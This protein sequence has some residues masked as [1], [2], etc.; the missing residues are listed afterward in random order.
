MSRSPVVLLVVSGLALAAR[1]QVEA[2]RP[3][4]RLV[5][6]VVQWDGRPVAGAALHFGSLEEQLT[7]ATLLQPQASSDAEG[8]FAVVVAPPQRDAEET[9][10]LFVAA[11]GM[12]AVARAVPWRFAGDPP[13]GPPADELVDDGGEYVPL[14]ARPVRE[15]AAETQVGDVVLIPGARLVGRVRDAAGKPVAGV[16]VVARDLLEVGNGAGGDGFT[17]GMV[18]RIV[19][20]HGAQGILQGGFLCT[21]RSDA[22]GI[23]DLPCALPL[24]SVL[25]FSLAGHYR[26]RIAPVATGTPLEVTLRRSGWIQGRVLDAEGRSIAD[27]QVIVD[28]ELPDDRTPLRTGPDGSFRTW[29]TRPGR[30]RATAHKQDD[31][32]TFTGYS[33]VFTG[34]RENFELIAKVDEHEQAQRLPLRVVAKATGHPVPGFRALAI[35]DEYANQNVNYLEYRMRSALRGATPGKDGAGEVPGPGEGAAAIGAVRVVAPGFAPFTK[36]QVEWK[37]P[38]AG[39]PHETLAIEL[40][41]EA[42]L[43]GTVVDETTQQPVAGARVFARPRLDPSQGDYGDG[44]RLPAG[45]ATTGADGTFL[46]AGLGEGAWEV[47]VRDRRRPRCPPQEVELVAAQQKTGLV[48]A[49]PSGATVAGTLQGL[50]IGPAT[51]VF[52]AR[53]PRQAF[54]ETNGYFGDGFAGPPATEPVA[55]A[56][57][58]SFR[59]DGV[60]LDNHL[61]VV[62]VPSPPRLG[63]DLYLPIEPFRLRKGGLQR[64]FDGSEDRPG[65]IRGR[66]GFAAASVPFEQLV[67][68]APPVGDEGRIFFSP[69]D[70]SFP[71]PR[72]FV[73]PTGEYEVRV[74][75]GAYQLV[76]VD[77]ATSLALHS[78]QQRIAVAT[79]ATVER[80]LQLQLARVEVELAAAAGVPEMAAVDRIE[81]RVMTP[82][83]KA[84]GMQFGNNDNYDSGAG[85]P[86]PSGATSLELVLPAGDATLLCRN[87]VAHLRRDDERWNNP[88]LGRA[89][90]EIGLAA[91]ARTSRRIEVGP[92][93]EI[94]DPDAKKDGEGGAEPAADDRTRKAP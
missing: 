59:F 38:E 73:S 43:R 27:A 62:Q 47:V 80:D 4:V 48:V 72:S 32:R 86:W 7:A 46:L 94:P 20:G 92:P 14:Q 2:P 54:A 60:A 1:A 41:P 78:E 33:P 82:A 63:G 40:E 65:T 12:A 85:V 68:I 45:A 15:Y 35:W 21:A 13:G 39:Q 70:A 17:G 90:F 22:A 58:G 16:R 77:L 19:A 84:R 37:D 91:G 87:G 67:V 9:M 29:L 66:L 5:G 3:E 25:T 28:Q 56:G 6:R 76:V 36:Q 26:E 44:D 81:V 79:G 10:L 11:K 53:L 88:P 71:G 18:V 30:W 69:Q 52:L 57:D 24:G 49:V 74:G 50:P 89:E 64:A 23:F 93:P 51:R 42:T 55:I 8:R 34:P 31:K 75:P 61:L 83:M